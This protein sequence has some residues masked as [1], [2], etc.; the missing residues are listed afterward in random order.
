[1]VGE[2]HLQSSVHDLCAVID[3]SAWLAQLVER[4]TAV[5]EVEGSSP[6]SY[7]CNYIR[8]WFEVQVFSDKD[9]KP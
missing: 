9:Y 3:A 7:L 4:Q 5:R 6:M 1:M 8:K 2:E